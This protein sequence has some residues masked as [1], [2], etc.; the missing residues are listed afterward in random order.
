MCRYWGSY[1]R[2]A[3]ILV[4]NCLSLTK[5]AGTHGQLTPKDGNKTGNINVKNFHRSLST[6]VGAQNDTSKTAHITDIIFNKK[7]DNT[8]KSPKC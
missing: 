3:Y 8:L 1:D 6:V 5:V 2:L 7:G 4:A